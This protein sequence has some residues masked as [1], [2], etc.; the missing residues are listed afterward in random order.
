MTVNTDVDSLSEDERSCY[1]EYSG[2]SDNSN[3][4]SKSSDVESDGTVMWSCFQ[5][6]IAKIKQNEKTKTIT[7]INPYKIILNI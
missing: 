3:D 4:C 7:T 2:D 6:V 1:Y 5:L